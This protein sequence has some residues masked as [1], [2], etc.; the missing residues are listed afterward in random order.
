MY[1]NFWYSIKLV[2]RIK[3]GDWVNTLD[4]GWITYDLYLNYQ[5]MGYDPGVIKFELKKINNDKTQ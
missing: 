4:H 5:S 2:R 3:G 1:K